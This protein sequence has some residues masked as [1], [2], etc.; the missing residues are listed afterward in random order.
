MHK[1]AFHTDIPKM[2]NKVL[3]DPIHWSYQLYLFSKNLN[4]DE[5]IE[6]KF[7]RT[8]I[9]GARPSGSLAV[10]AL[11]RTVEQCKDAFPLAYSPIV[12]DTYMDDCA[13]GILSI[14]IKPCVS[15]TK[16]RPQLAKLVLP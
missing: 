11:R 4:L 5:E 9:Y 8:L 13:S 15:L 7:V 16:C 3:L 14:M 1:S 6:W 2:Y 10:S 12:D